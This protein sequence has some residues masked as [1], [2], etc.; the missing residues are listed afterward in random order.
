MKVWMSE[1][2]FNHPWET[3]VAAAWQKYPNPIT[4]SVLGTDVIDRKVVD[5]KL[6]SLR[7]VS[8]Q[9]G[10]PRW[11]KPRITQKLIVSAKYYMYARAPEDSTTSDQVRS[12]LINRFSGCVY[13]QEQQALTFYNYITVD[14]TV[15]YTPHPKD[16]KK[17]LLTQE[18]VVKVHGVP[19]THYMERSFGVENFFQRKQILYTVTLVELY[20]NNE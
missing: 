12:V 11:T 7:L 2:I 16:D 4:P 9:W 17:T 6:K 19:L 8:S 13:T 14:E 18:A 15:R 5:G 3:V 1:H 10:F 20:R